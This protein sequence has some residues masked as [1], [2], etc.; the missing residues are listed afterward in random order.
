MSQPAARFAGIRWQ[1][2]L[3]VI[4]GSH[5]CCMLVCFQQFLMVSALMSSHACFAITT[6]SRRLILYISS[7]PALSWS[8][9]QQ[10][11]LVSTLWLILKDMTGK[12]VQGECDVMV[13]HL[14][15][16][17]PLFNPPKV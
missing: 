13:L 11:N 17:I 3:R 4:M 7:S 1:G 10:Q 9:T 6:A 2:G 14:Q 5:G 8:I 16:N 15:F 12:V